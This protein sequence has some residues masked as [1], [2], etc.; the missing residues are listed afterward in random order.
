MQ[1]QVLSHTWGLWEHFPPALT[2]PSPLPELAFPPHLTGPA[3]SLLQQVSY[4]E[5]L[6]T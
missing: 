6:H 4:P 3:A 1:V 5:V 2:Q